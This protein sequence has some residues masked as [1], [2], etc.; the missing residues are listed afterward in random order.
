VFCA[1]DL[2]ALGA[3]DVLQAAGRK[4]PV[5]GVDMIPSA[6]FSVKNGGLTVTV[7]VDGGEVVSGLLHAVDSYLSSGTV[8]S[9]CLARNQVVTQSSLLQRRRQKRRFL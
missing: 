6:V 5:G 7:G 4:I 2:M 1:N 8:I 3:L 9:N